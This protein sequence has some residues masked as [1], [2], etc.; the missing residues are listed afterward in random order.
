MQAPG[1][2]LELAH[3]LQLSKGQATRLRLVLALAFRPRV[4][5]LDEPATG[6]DPAGRRTLLSYPLPSVLRQC[7]TWC[8]GQACKPPRNDA[9]C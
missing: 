3:P 7:I 1:V 6:L 9:M 8:I 2:W 4:L 5:V